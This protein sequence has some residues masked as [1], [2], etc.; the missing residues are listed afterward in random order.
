MY[1]FAIAILLSLTNVEGLR[2]RN[3]A[4]DPVADEILGLAQVNYP[5]LQDLDGDGMICWGDYRA[6]ILSRY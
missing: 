4:T 2:V 5:Q 6:F 3:R 1:K